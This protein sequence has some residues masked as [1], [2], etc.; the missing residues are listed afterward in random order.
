[1]CGHLLTVEYDIDEITT[2]R[3][4][5]NRRPISIWR[6]KEFLP[7]RIKPVTLQEGVTP[8]YHLKKLGEKFGLP[9]LY[10]KHEDMNPSGSFKD[11]GI[12]LDVSMSKL[13]DKCSVAHASTDNTSASM[14]VYAAIAGMPAVVLL[15]TWHVALGKVTQALM[16]GAK[17]ISTRGNFDRVLEMVHEFCVNHGIYFLNS[18]NPYRQEGKKTIGFEAIDQ[19]GCVPDRMVLPVGNAGNISP[20]S[21]KICASGVMSATSTL[22]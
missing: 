19:L 8:L 3:E 20:R 4:E 17:I 6:Y 1:M 12:A 10:A 18:I 9:H 13:R 15:L 5:L 7:V 16:H 11:R 14:A 21:T 2:P 22:Y